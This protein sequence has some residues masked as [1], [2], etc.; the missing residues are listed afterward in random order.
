[1]TDIVFK[2]KLS[3]RWQRLVELMQTINFGRIED[4]RFCSGEP[5]FDPPPRVIRKIKPGSDNGPRKETSLQ[6]FH[7]KRHITELLIAFADENDLKVSIEVKA[8]L[9]VTA[10]VES[11]TFLD[12]S[13]T[14]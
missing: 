2:S 13:R 14:E 11:P 3:A 9:P 6:D 5:M 7:L 8:G 4:L 12:K 10:E 1:L